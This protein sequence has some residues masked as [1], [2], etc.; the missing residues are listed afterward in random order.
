VSE[1][2]WSI[3]RGTE[4]KPICNIVNTPVQAM[5][6]NIAVVTSHSGMGISFL[7]LLRVLVFISVGIVS[8]LVLGVVL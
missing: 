6:I 3:A 5:S 8:K 1:E 4:S 7:V 2:R